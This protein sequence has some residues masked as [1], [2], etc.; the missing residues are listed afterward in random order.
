MS[1]QPSSPDDELQKAIKSADMLMRI[2]PYHSC[3]KVLLSAAKRTLSAEQ[4]SQQIDRVN[5]ELENK[6]VE[7]EKDKGCIH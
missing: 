1:A 4:H 7:L 2:Y 3:F 5:A 6:I